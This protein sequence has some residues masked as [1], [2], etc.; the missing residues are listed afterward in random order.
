[1]KQF[2]RKD[3]EMVKREFDNGNNL[4]FVKDNK[5]FKVIIL[6]ECID[7]RGNTKDSTYELDGSLFNHER[8]TDTEWEYWNFQ[9]CHFYILTKE[10]AKPYLKKIMM[11]KMLTAKS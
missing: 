11:N 6:I 1:M 8:H 10:E 9:G 5:D 7:A 2:E 4:W 3:L